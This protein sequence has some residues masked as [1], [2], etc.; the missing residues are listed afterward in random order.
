MRS[1]TRPGNDARATRI[2][3]LATVAAGIAAVSAI[4][5]SAI[6]VSAADRGTADVP[7]GADRRHRTGV[8]ASSPVAPADTAV[9]HRAEQLLLQKCMAGAGFRYWPMP[10]KPTPDYRL[11]RY[12][13]TDV[14]WAKRHGYG[15][16]LHR[17]IEQESLTSP[18]VRYS[19]SLSAQRRHAMGAAINGRRPVG[20]SVR[21]PIGGT[22]THSDEGCTATVWKRLYGDSQAWFAA[23]Q[24]TTNLGAIQANQVMS[25]PEYATGLARWR[26]CMGP[27]GYPD[28]DPGALRGRILSA[29]PPN[30]AQEIRAATAEATCAT[31]SGFTALV[32]QLDQRHDLA[33]Q[34]EY[35]P[36][37]RSMWSMQRAALPLAHSVLAGASG[38]G[39]ERY[40]DPKEQ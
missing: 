9:L 20:L 29:S 38:P 34:P 8:L 33:L 2:L 19:K 3:T 10:E 6:T 17:R 21:N 14:G 12:F 7:T 32:Q 23:R 22:L 15:R 35:R 16:D 13:V 40:T 37:Y 5:I 11:F 27:A 31:T 24:I 28:R 26:T 25:D 1:R 36:T 39:S 4:T 30:L 18:A